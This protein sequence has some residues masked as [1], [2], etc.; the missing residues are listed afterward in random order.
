[1]KTRRREAVPDEVGETNKRR[2]I[3]FGWRVVGAALWVILEVAALA[4]LLWR[5]W[6]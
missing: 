5:L 2:R 1:M 3:V 6:E 4:A